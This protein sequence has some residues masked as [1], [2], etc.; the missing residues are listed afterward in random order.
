MGVKTKALPSPLCFVGSGGVA[1]SPVCNEPVTPPYSNPSMLSFGSSRHH[2]AC[3]SCPTPL[4]VEPPPWKARRQKECP[5]GVLFPPN[6]C[7]LSNMLS[8][9][10]LF[11]INISKVIS[12]SLSGPWS[13]GQVTFTMPPCISH[14][15]AFGRP[16]GSED[17]CY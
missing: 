7:L 11:L 2:G 1:L 8:F 16:L 3:Y 9:A 17:A 14:W 5:Q 4:D 15:P 10:S 12:Q 6:A 13:F